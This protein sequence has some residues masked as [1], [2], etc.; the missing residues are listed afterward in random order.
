MPLYYFFL[1][2][3]IGLWFVSFIKAKPII[4]KQ[5]KLNSR[6]FEDGACQASLVKKEP[7]LNSISFNQ[8]RACQASR[9][10]KVLIRLF[11]PYQQ[12]RNFHTTNR[13]IIKRR[14]SLYD[15]VAC[16]ENKISI[17]SSASPQAQD[18]IISIIFEFNKYFNKPIKETGLKSSIFILIISYI[19]YLCFDLSTNQFQFVREYYN[20]GFFDICLGIDGCSIYFVVRPSEIRLR[21]SFRCKGKIIKFRGFLKIMVPS[22]NW[23]IESGWTNSSCMVISPNMIEREIDN[24]G[25]KP[26]IP[27]KIMRKEG[28]AVKEQRVDGSYTNSV[29]KCTLTNYDSNCQAKILSNQ[30]IPPFYET[31]IASSLTQGSC[32]HSAGSKKLSFRFAAKRSF[33]TTTRLCHL[34]A[35]GGRGLNG[36]SLDP[37]FV[38]GFVDAEV[39]FIVHIRKLPRNNT[40]WRVEGVLK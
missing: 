7:K 3:I 14:K 9:V 5:L 35:E 32:P 33:M 26:A 30:Q 31:S 24:R 37:W 22:C 6:S 10:K 16:A 18:H 2:P 40:G 36:R 12:L 8:G 17:E 29:L 34:A 11:P 38:T 20:L 4:K 21:K 1:I 25:S 27:L 15:V 23:K 13:P 19:I 39:S 28:I